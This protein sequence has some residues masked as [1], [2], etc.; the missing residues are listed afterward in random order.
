MQATKVARK[1]KTPPFLIYASRQRWRGRGK[2][3]SF[4]SSMQAAKV[5]RKGK[6]PPFP[7]K[8]PSG[9]GREKRLH[10]SLL[11]KPPKVARRGK[12]PS[13]LSMQATKVARK[14]QNAFTPLYASCL[15]GDEPPG[16]SP[17]A[18]INAQKRADAPLRS[19]EGTMGGAWLRHAPPIVP[20]R[21]QRSCEVCP[22]RMG[23]PSMNP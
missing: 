9:R 17:P 22:S 4:L 20:S 16:L 18:A 2:T 23:K 14:G 8:L 1:G 15:R 11:C 3:P 10:S 6:T 19:L 5:A 21:E 12:T 13:L 7:C